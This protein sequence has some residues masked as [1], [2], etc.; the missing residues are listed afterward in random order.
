MGSRV[1]RLILI[2]VVVLII[3]WAL[4]FIAAGAQVTY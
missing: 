2:Y 1:P 4:S 3:P